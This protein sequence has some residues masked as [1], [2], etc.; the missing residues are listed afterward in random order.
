[1]HGGCGP[2]HSASWGTW[3]PLFQFECEELAALRAE[4]AK[5][6]R[7]LGDMPL[8]VITRGKSDADGPDGV[9]FAEEH[10]KDQTALATLSRHGSLVIAAESGHHVQIEQ[11]QLVVDAIRQAI[12]RP[13]P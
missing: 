2:G 11:P 6:E 10:R 8:V 1:M 5:V 3:R 4:R 7:P 9:K 13:R 12:A